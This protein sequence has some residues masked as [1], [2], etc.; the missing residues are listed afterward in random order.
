MNPFAAPR[1]GSG[2]ISTVRRGRAFFSMS[3]GAFL[4]VLVSIICYSFV[5]A[6]PRI[7]RVCQYLAEWALGLS[8]SAAGFAWLG[9]VIARPRPIVLA[10]AIS[11]ASATGIIHFLLTYIPINPLSMY[12][13]CVLLE[14]LA[15]FLSVISLVCMLVPFKLRQMLVK[16]AGSTRTLDAMGQVA[17]THI[18]PT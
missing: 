17:A 5:C 12:F 14:L 16:A 1:Y 13:I 15:G 3:N 2:S 8:F 9:S 11:Y 18:V 7:S 10:G 6:S 4:F